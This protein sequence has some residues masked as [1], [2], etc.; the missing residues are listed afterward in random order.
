MEQR[1]RLYLRAAHY[2]NTGEGERI[3]KASGLSLRRMARLIGVD[4]TTLRS[5]EIGRTGWPRDE[6]AAARWV[7]ELDAL[8]RISSEEGK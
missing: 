8:A 7:R 3:R 6:A 1:M 4:F 2:A 5:W